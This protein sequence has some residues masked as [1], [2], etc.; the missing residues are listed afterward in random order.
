MLSKV[1]FVFFLFIFSIYCQNVQCPS[2][3]NPTDGTIWKLSDKGVITWTPGGPNV[4]VNIKLRKGIASAMKEIAIIGNNID[5]NAKTFTWNIPEN[6][7]PDSDYA[8]EIGLSP[9]V[10]YS[11]YFTIADNGSVPY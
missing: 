11:H 9:N 4:K 1:I 2:I 3:T 5:Q 6:L 8:I 7:T 10:C